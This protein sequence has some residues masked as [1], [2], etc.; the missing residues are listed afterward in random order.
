M[1][2]MGTVVSL[3]TVEGVEEPEGLQSTF[4]STS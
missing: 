4:V 2:A 1:K 3:R